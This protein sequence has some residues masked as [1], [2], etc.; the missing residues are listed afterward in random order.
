MAN[1]EYERA[2][3]FPLTTRPIGGVAKS[4]ISNGHFVS[5]GVMKRAPVLCISSSIASG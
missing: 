3:I 5:S 1:D 2:L 4:L